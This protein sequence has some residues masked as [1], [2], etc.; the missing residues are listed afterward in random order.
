MAGVGGARRGSAPAAVDRRGEPAAVEVEAVVP[1]P[2]GAGDGGVC[3]AAA[4]VGSG[5]VAAYAAA[6]K[7]VT[8]DVDGEVT[9]VETFEGDVSDLLAGEGVEVSRRDAVTPAVDGALREG[10]TV[11]VRYGHRVTLR[12]D[13]EQ[14][15]AWVTALDADQALTKLSKQGDDVLLLP[16]RSD[17]SVTLPMR[18]DVDG[19]VKLV[20]GGQARR[21]ADGAM[22]L[23]RLLAE[24]EV[25]VDADDR[26]TVERRHPTTPGAPTVAVVVREVQTSIEETVS[27][28][29]FESVTAADPNRYE[30]LGPYLATEGVVGKRVTSWDVTK[31]DGKVVH[32]EKLST[33]VAERPVDEVT[34]YGTKA[35]PEPEPKPKSEP[36]PDPKPDS[37]TDAKPKPDSTPTPDSTPDSKLDVESPDEK[38]RAQS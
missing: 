32:K 10:D 6:H 38:T 9:T 33:W 8:L 31:I 1:S 34:M 35:R 15:A 20:V 23:D 21:V 5:G 30:D 17:G 25:R 26:V 16:T 7:T 24:N 29:P 14:R 27:E 22:P 37:K 11:V 3:A 2:P 19:P 18:I 4:G 28:V 36:K 12:V 13:G